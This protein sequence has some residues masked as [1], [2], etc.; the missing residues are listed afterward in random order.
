MAQTRRLVLRV[1]RRSIHEGGAWLERTQGALQGVGHEWDNGGHGQD[2]VSS[3]PA[4]SLAV[5]RRPSVAAVLGFVWP[6]VGHLY[7]GRGRAGVLL[8]VLFPIASL[9]LSLLA[10]LVPVAV[11]CVA[12]PAVLTLA[13]HLVVARGAARAVSRFPRDRPLPFFSRWYSCLVAVVLTAGL[14]PLWAQGYR[15]TFVQAFKIPTGGM[16]PTIRIGD[17]LVAVMW[18]YGWREPLSGRLI[19]SARQPKRGDLVIFRFPEDRSRTFIKRCIGLPGEV[20]QVRG[21][22]VL[23]DGQP[24]DEPYVQFLDGSL[25]PAGVA[26]EPSGPSGKWG[27]QVVPLGQYFVLGDNRDNSRDS[28]FWGFVPQEDLLGRASVVY[29]SYAATRE[30][31]RSTDTPHW[32][33]HTW[34]SFRR[35]RWERI[36][37]PL[38]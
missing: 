7:A 37:R 26:P 5:S 14:N 32:L 29:W 36:G 20:V 33:E 13:L 9:S 17:H 3:L 28:R 15:T 27:P 38:R 23:I 31:Y 11:L 2:D 8:L 4:P 25:T 21:R 16:E 24:L 10:V 12:I 6:G 22:A 19:S 34:S 30:D 18:A 35:T 1:Y